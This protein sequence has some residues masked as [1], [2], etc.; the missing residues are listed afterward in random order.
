VGPEGY[1]SEGMVNVFQEAG[2]RIIG[3]KKEAAILEGSKC[4]TKDLLKSLK[5][6]V[7]PFQN[8]SDAA[9]AKE[10]A[11]QYCAENPKKGLVIKADAWRLE[12]GL[13]YVAHL[14]R[15]CRP[16]TESW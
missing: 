2:Q 4:F 8:F 6:P 7:P 5:V 12:R 16:S 1:L 9:E 14:L 15:P 3:P 10:Y 13:W 11:L